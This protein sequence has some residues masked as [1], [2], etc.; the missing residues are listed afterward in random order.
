MKSITF[1]RLEIYFVDWTDYYSLIHSSIVD[2]KRSSPTDNVLLNLI[3]KYY[4]QSAN[5]P[6]LKKKRLSRK[7]SQ[8]PT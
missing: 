2:V 8:F 6:P 5:I 3:S 1:E 7:I 4:L